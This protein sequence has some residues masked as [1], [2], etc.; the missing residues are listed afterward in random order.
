MSLEFKCDKCRKALKEPG[1]LVFSPP[2]G[3]QVMKF[4]ICNECYFSVRNWFLGDDLLEPQ[5]V[6]KNFERDFKNARKSNK[7]SLRK[8]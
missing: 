7:S 4:H 2:A 3:Y 1:G 6:R 8:R 5:V